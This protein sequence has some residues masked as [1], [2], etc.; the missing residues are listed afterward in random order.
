MIRVC[1][2]LNQQSVNG[3]KLS[4]YHHRYRRFMEDVSSVG[5]ESSSRNE[6]TQ[7]SPERASMMPEWQWCEEGFELPEETAVER[8]SLA[9]VLCW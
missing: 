2:F 4:G 6:R 5:D 9:R 1:G 3:R 8:C 7:H